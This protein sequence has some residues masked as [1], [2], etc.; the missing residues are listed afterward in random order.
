M[1][2]TLI[3][4]RAC[5]LEAHVWPLDQNLGQCGKMYRGVTRSRRSDIGMI[6]VDDFL[7]ATDGATSL[8]GPC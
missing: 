1:G 2:G 4:T 3:R 5:D 8:E 7:V 6:N